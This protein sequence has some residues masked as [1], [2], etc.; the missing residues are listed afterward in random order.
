M[1]ASIG[2]HAPPRAST[3]LVHGEGGVDAGAVD[4]LALLV[5]AANRGAHALGGH[6][7]H[8]DV[9]AEVHAVV[10]RPT[11]KAKARI[12]TGRG[13]GQHRQ[14]RINTGR[15]GGQRELRSI[16]VEGGQRER[17]MSGHAT[18]GMPA[19]LPVRSAQSGHDTSSLTCGEPS[20]AAAAV[21]NAPASRPAGSRGT[22]P[23]WSRASWRPGCE[24]TAWPARWGRRQ[25]S[26][27][28]K[29]PSHA[30]HW[31]SEAA[32]WRQAG[33]PCCWGTAKQRLPSTVGRE[34]SQGGR[35]RPMPCTGPAV[36]GARR[37]AGA[38]WLGPH[39]GGVGD[40]QDDHVAL[41][42]HV[43]HL[44][45]GAVGLGEAHGAGLLAGGGVGAQADD[46]LQG[47]R[48]YSCCNKYDSYGTSGPGQR[49]SRL[50]SG[51]GLAAAAPADAHAA[52]Q[53]FVPEPACLNRKLIA[54]SAAA[55]CRHGCSM[56]QTDAIR[57]LHRAASCRLRT[58]GWPLLPPSGH[59]WCCAP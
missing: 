58:R 36:H 20:R 2:C 23:G 39:L 1:P 27:A 28:R 49:G 8:V 13:G 57:G 9:R 30:R 40:E 59:R 18:V 51:D 32:V 10:L 19:A 24:G 53:G 3:H 6:Q 17:R 31:A 42:D 12:N 37:P 54:E 11:T 21:Q 48:T 34:S 38:S 15:G 56:L 35:K 5:Q 16:K 55:G 41:G 46:H 43:K 47:H 50:S 33:R 25:G 22:G 52:P 26:E 44:A 29:K 7:N 4:R 45:Q 14:R